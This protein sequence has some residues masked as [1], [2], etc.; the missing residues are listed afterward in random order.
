MDFK[1]TQM[2]TMCN[3]YSAYIY[4]LLVYKML[5]DYVAALIIKQKY[6]LPLHKTIDSTK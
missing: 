4:S 1:Q 6:L 2:Y 3:I 5:I